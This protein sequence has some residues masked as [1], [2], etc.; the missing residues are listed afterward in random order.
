VVTSIPL[1]E[2]QEGWALVAVIVVWG[3]PDS[4]IPPAPKTKG[5]PVFS[6]RLLAQISADST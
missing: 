3:L 6:V 2:V 5:Y 4:T 1:P